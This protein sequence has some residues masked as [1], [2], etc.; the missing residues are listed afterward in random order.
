MLGVQ[1][2]PAVAEGVLV[3]AWGQ[4]G[5]VGPSAGVGVQFPYRA[6]GDA[7]GA[8]AVVE[9]NVENAVGIDL[10]VD[11]VQAERLAGDGGP[12]SAAID[13]VE[14]AGLVAFGNADIDVA[15]RLTSGDAAG[16][17]DDETDARAASAAES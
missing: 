15:R 13:A 7:V 2:Q 3:V 17:E 10:A 6:A 4:G 1:A 16:I 11:G 8:D 12:A 9:A 5:N 14:E